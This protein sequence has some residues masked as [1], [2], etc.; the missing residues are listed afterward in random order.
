MR[1][2]ILTADAGP[3]V[4]RGTALARP[5]CTG[6]PRLYENAPPLDPTVGLCVGSYGGWVF[7]YGRDTHVRRARIG[8]TLEPLLPSEV[9]CGFYLQ[10]YLA[11]EKSPT[12]L[13]PPEDPRHRPTVG[14]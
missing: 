2:G 7:S 3:R 11:H 10:G 12:P 6:V 8:M 13:G 4:P 9:Y 1:P 5:G 14:T